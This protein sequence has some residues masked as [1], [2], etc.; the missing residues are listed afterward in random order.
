MRRS[1]DAPANLAPR[2]EDAQQG[3]QPMH[4]GGVMPR[5]HGVRILACAMV[6]IVATLHGPRGLHATTRQQTNERRLPAPFAS[7]HIT[8]SVLMGAPW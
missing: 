1:I 4:A 3:L 2:S 6:C 5:V 8:R 7:L